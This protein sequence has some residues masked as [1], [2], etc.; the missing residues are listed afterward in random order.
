MRKSFGVICPADAPGASCS[1]RSDITR[2]LGRFRSPEAWLAW[3]DFLIEYNAVLYHTVH[4]FAP[5]EDQAGDCF[6]Y[7]CEQLARNG[8]RRLLQFKTDGAANFSTWL[9]VVT[10]NL[11]FD[12]HRKKHGRIRPLKSVQGLSPLGLEAYRCLYERCLSP[13]E[14]LQQLRAT[15]PTVTM[16]ELSDIESTIEN[17]LS[18]RQHWIL[19]ARK[20]RESITRAFSGNE[21]ETGEETASTIDTGPNPERL[22]VDQQ[23]RARLHKCVGLL[24]PTERL[25]VRLR[26]EDELSLDEIGQ[27]TGLG[28]AQRVH[29][30]LAEILRKLRVAIGEINDRKT[31]NGV[32]EIRRETR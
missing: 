31:L 23:Q 24:P 26:F 2:I 30:R 1:Y 14:T 13:E 32:R 4:K 17:S 9:R 22:A 18:S 19:S 6:V 27:L 8:F 28:D 25:I 21:E 11:C 29:R 12:W 20:Q 16:V 3:E 5:D 15:W 10:R 7:I